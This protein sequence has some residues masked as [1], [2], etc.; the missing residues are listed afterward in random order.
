MKKII[1]YI[2]EP[3]LKPVRAFILKTVIASAKYGRLKQV[4]ES[5]MPD[6]SPRR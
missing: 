6:E 5:H 3:L 4:I 1:S 2:I